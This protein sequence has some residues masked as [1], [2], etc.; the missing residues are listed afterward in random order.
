MAR[1]TRQR[2]AVIGLG[3]F[4]S[5]L[6]REMAS[7]G[8]DV[9][10]ID[11]DEHIVQSLASDLTFVVAAD[12]TSE[13]AM[14]QLG[15]HEMDAVIIGIGTYLEASILTAT[16]MLE[17]NVPSVWAKA[18]SAD[19]GR[20]LERL[21]VHHVVY[22]EYDMGRRVAH[23]VQTHMQDFVELDEGF[24]FAKIPAPTVFEGRTAAQIHPRDVYG[25]A[26][27]AVRRASGNYEQVLRDTVLHGGDIL[28]VVGENRRLQEFALLD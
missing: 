20:I 25:I 18:T 23:L 8:G 19:H 22:P 2:I 11:T 26:I 7:M 4:G 6:A 17:L 21:G 10:G 24:A 27:V 9:L 5:A 16:L 1:K 15:V 28:V 3:R 12:S 14:R 13:K